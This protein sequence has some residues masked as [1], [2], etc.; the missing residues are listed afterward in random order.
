M[1]R[2]DM[3]MCLYVDDVPACLNMKNLLKVEIPGSL[4]HENHAG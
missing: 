2:L 3:T 1:S 4:D